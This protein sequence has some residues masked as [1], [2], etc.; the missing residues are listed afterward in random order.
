GWVEWQRPG[1]DLGLQSK[2]CLENNPDIRGSMVGGHGSFTWGDTAYECYINSL[3]VI[4]TCA[5]YLAQ[6]YGKRRPVF[7][8]QK[9]KA[10]SRTDSIK[11]SSKIA[12]VLRGL[13]SSERPMVGRFS[14]Y[15]R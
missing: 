3:E 9:I 12:P 1:F 4:E 2:K 13:C 10:L 7:G 11:L 14:D 6:N 15:E 8:G 5:E